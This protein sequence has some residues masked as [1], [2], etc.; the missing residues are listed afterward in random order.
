MTL[1]VSRCLRSLVKPRSPPASNPGI[2]AAAF[3]RIAQYHHKNEQSPIDDHAITSHLKRS[4]KQFLQC[5]F[6]LK[7]VGTVDRF[8]NFI[9]L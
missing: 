7:R 1:I 4:G 5:F 9:K 3:N 2:V 6:T 8:K